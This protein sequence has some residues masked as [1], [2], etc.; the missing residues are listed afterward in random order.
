MI[1]DFSYL[2]D[3]LGNSIGASFQ[4]LAL[5]ISVFIMRKLPIDWELFFSED[6]KSL[7]DKSLKLF[8][9]LTAFRIFSSFMTNG[10]YQFYHRFDTTVSV[11]IFT[12][13]FFWW[14]YV[15]HEQQTHY[16]LETIKR[17]EEDNRTMQETVNKLG[18]L[19]NEIRGFRHDFGSIIASMEPALARN[20]IDEIREI[21]Q[22]IFLK[23]NE[24][25]IKS[26]YTAFNLQNI[27]DIP[28]RNVLAKTMIS[29][30]NQEIPVTLQTTGYV[31]KLDIPMLEAVRMLSILT[32]NALE[33]T[34]E[35]ETPQIDIALITDDNTVTFIIKNTREKL[36]LE[37]NRL[38][39]RG[40]S[41]KEEGRGTGLATLED[42][43]F[44][45]DLALDTQIGEEIFTQILELPMRKEK[46][47]T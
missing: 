28:L 7:F 2:H 39:Q 45:Y 40:Y 3:M 38:S 32:T 27:E 14:L 6:F 41:T 33:A 46:K 16:D 34:R 30:Q 9:P 19:Y 1:F 4:F 42:M 31:R 23:T 26:D 24:K 18:S 43:V 22:D 8:I 37:Q 5:F 15:K 12:A 17:Q 20:D 29:A 35:A 36:V 13:F 44:E 25:L 11:I 10:N 47:K 21:Y